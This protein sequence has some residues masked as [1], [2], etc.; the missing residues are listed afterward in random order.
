M[1]VMGYCSGGT[2][3][4][5]CGYQCTLY[6]VLCVVLNFVTKNKLLEVLIIGNI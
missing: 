1:K 5:V 6:F 4:A 3:S 2:Q